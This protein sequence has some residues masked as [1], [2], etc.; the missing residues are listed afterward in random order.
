MRSSIMFVV[1][2]ITTITALSLGV[3]FAEKSM[4]NATK[5]TTTIN[6]TANM[7]DLQNVVKQLQSVTMQLQN[8]TEQL[9]KATKQQNV[10]KLQNMTNLQN[11]TKLL[12]SATEQMQN[13][14]NPFANAKGRK[15]VIP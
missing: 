13:A 15:P 2:L 10:T 9:Q 12:K 4:S 14:T 6:A 3:A 8:V 1:V 5:P 11:A 7:I